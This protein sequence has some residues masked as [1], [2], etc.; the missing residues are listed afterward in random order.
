MWERHQ[1]YERRLGQRR[2]YRPVGMHGEA[3]A[4]AAVVVD[5]LADL[6]SESQ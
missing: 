5:V 4:V 6:L 3:G 1:W 2:G